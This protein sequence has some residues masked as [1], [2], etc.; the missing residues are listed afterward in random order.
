M[1]Y[2]I[3][4]NTKQDFRKKKELLNIQITSVT[5]S[6]LQQECVYTLLYLSYFCSLVY[7]QTLFCSFRLRFKNNIYI[8]QFPFN[9]VNVIIFKD[10]LKEKKETN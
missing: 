7:T 10:L 4:H 8:K 5:V 9:F 3:V 1:S 6:I 2:A